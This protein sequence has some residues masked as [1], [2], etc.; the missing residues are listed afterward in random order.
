[1][2]SS[3][4]VRKKVIKFLSENF[5]L[6]TS[7]SKISE[8]LSVFSIKGNENNIKLQFLNVEIMESFV[9]FFL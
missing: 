1:M 2:I 9:E 5:P 3:W 6:I 4:Q 7:I 8:T